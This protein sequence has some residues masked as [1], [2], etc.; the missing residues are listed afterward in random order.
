M[1]KQKEI[2]DKEYTLNENKWKKFTKNLPEIFTGKVV[3]EIGV[4]NGKTLASIVRQKPKK[5]T[6]IDFS[7]KAISLCKSNFSKDKIDFKEM[8]VLDLDFEDESFDII[9]CHYVLN[10]LLSDDRTMAVSE[11]LRC[12]KKKGKL[13]FEDFHQGDLRQKLGEEH[14]EYNTIMK[15]NSLICHFFDKKE[16]LNLFSGMKSK[17]IN[18]LISNPIRGEKK[19]AR[20]IISAV[21]EK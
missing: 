6:A 15:N 19:I 4:G 9:V 2:W 14:M 18:V 12:L 8:D 1:K 16:V 21:F 20:K 17:K 7:A 3:L 10:N 5:V 13:V 11:M